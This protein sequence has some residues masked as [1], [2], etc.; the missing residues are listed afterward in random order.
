MALFQ[1]LVVTICFVLRELRGRVYSR[2]K[3]KCLIS[4]YSLLLPE[5]LYNPPP[6][7]CYF[8]CV[9][10]LKLVVKMSFIVNYKW[11]NYIY[12]LRTSEGLLRFKF[13]RKLNGAV[14]GAPDPVRAHE[15][16]ASTFD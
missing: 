8:T 9:L 6:I 14:F 1:V 2:Y 12:G 7:R 4:N 15:G 3:K 16:L 5:I 11:L 13:N 10:L